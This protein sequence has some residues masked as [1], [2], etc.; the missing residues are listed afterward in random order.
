MVLTQ[1]AFGQGQRCNL[2]AEQILHCGWPT[3]IRDVLPCGVGFAEQH[4]L[5]KMRQRAGSGRTD[6]RCGRVL[7]GVATGGDRSAARRNAYA[8]VGQVHLRVSHYRTDIA[9]AAAEGRVLVPG[10]A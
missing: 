1:Q 7:A 9:A 2:A 4:G 6:V 5:Q 3:R 10:T 8:R